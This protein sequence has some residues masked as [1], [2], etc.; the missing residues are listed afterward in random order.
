VSDIIKKI[1]A[2]KDTERKILVG[3]ILENE[4]GLREVLCLLLKK[5]DEPLREKFYTSLSAGW[6]GYIKELA[7]KEVPLKPGQEQKALDEISRMLDGIGTRMEKLERNTVKAKKQTLKFRET[8]KAGFIKLEELISDQTKGLDRGPLQKEYPKDAEVISLPQPDRSVATKPD[9]FDCIAD[10]V[11]RRRFSE[12]QLSLAELSYLLWAT[13]GIRKMRG[14]AVAFRTVPSGGCMHPFETYLA[15]N[16]VEGIKP[17]L[18]RYQ[19]VDHR[20][21]KLAEV[22]QMKKKLARAALGQEFVGQCAAT[23]IWSAVPYRTEWR[24]TLA[25]RKIILQDSGHLC[26]NLYLACE[27]IGCGTCAIGAYNQKLFDKLCGLDGRDEFVV[28]VAPVGK[29]EAK[30]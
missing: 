18:Y 9:I 24:Y 4:K 28:Y 11:S 6:S 22:S 8:M 1:V 20:L 19:P 12:A 26:Q 10:R 14:S 29:A 17:G 30:S 25:A 27:S 13:Q 5:A 21:V 2:L 7:E 3:D 23:F 15:I 16:H